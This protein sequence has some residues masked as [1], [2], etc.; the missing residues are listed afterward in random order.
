MQQQNN[1]IQTQNN[2]GTTEKYAIRRGQRLQCK[3][4]EI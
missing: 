1:G 4:S 3:L 2:S